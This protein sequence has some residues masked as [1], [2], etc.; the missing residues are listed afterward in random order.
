MNGNDV[1]VYFMLPSLR[2][3]SFYVEADP[4]ASRPGSGLARE[5][6]HADV[7]I[8]GR[9]WNADREANGTEL[10]G[11][12]APNRVVRQRFCQR[13]AFDGYQVLTRCR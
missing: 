7:L 8:L 3:A 13:G 1:F 5:L 2:P 12:A 6:A 10:Y 4:P 11:S 9:R